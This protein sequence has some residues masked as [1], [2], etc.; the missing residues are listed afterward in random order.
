MKQNAVFSFI[1]L[2][3]PLFIGRVLG[4][5]IH[6]FKL[7]DEFGGNIGV[8]NDQDVFIVSCVGVFAKVEGTQH[9]DFVINDNDL[10]MQG[11]GVAVLSTSFLLK[12]PKLK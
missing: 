12:G 7:S 3:D 8:V 5:C 4:H 6:P 9:D 10:V 2:P 1:L 11:V